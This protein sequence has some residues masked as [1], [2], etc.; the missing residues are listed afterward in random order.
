[1]TA[2]RHTTSG[3]ISSSLDN[4]KNKKQEQSYYFW[5]AGASQN[6]S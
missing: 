1:M 2:I 6:D 4:N 5:P 3:K